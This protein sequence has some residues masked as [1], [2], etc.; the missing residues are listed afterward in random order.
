MEF[1]IFLADIKKDNIKNKQNIALIC[2]HNPNTNIHSK[3]LIKG[4]YSVLQL[5]FWDIES[6]IKMSDNEIREVISDEK[7][8]TIKE[9]ILK[10]RDK[11]FLIHCSAG[12]SRSAA[13]GLAVETLLKSDF[14]MKNSLILKNERYDPNMVVYHKIVLSGVK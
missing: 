9:F 8:K 3:E 11:K 12:I 10:N 1:M 2:I 4:F 5:Q 7:A 14:E 6:P 13:V